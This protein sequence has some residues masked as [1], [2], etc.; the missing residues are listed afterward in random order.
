MIHFS[1]RL[2]KVAMPSKKGLIAS[3]P[4][5]RNTEQKQKQEQKQQHFRVLLELKHAQT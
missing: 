4:F 3:A 1:L 2:R 5:I